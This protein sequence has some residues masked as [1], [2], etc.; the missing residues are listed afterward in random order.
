MK[1]KHIVSKK[2]KTLAVGCCVTRKLGA[3]VHIDT[4]SD[5]GVVV[6]IKSQCMG[7]A[8]LREVAKLFSKIANV[9]DMQEAAEEL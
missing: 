1:T 8:D 2:E 3:R 4:H 7:A 5:L 6:L 9:L